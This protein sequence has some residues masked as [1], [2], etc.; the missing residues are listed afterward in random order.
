MLSWEEILK[1]GKTSSSNGHGSKQQRYRQKHA[2]HI[3]GNT[4]G[5]FQFVP[6]VLKRNRNLKFSPS[7]TCFSAYIPYF[8]EWQ[9]VPPRWLNYKQ[10]VSVSPI[11]SLTYISPYPHICL[12]L[13]LFLEFI[14]SL[15]P[16]FPLLLQLPFA[17]VSNGFLISLLVIHSFSLS[18]PFQIH[19]PFSCH[20]KQTK[21]LNTCLL[22]L[23]FI[24]P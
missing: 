8:S 20:T 19:I 3:S 6:T 10:E 24:R 1:N 9:H 17:R 16:S 13:H 15:S 5:P 7:S 2:Y 18:L 11:P 12:S 21:M 23:N 14:C 4:Q 22:Y